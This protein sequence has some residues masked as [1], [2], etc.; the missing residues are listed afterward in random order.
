MFSHAVFETKVANQSRT[1][2]H[3][4]LDGGS[5]VEGSACAHQPRCRKYAVRSGVTKENLKAV[6][7]TL[8]SDEPLPPISMLRVVDSDGIEVVDLTGV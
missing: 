4:R 7:E 8:L 2:C 6:G 5:R 1:L 3:G